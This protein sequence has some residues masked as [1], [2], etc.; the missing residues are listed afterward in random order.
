GAGPDRLH[1][2]RPP[3]RALATVKVAGPPAEGERSLGRPLPVNPAPRRR[4]LQ[5]SSACAA[6]AL[7]RGIRLR[8]NCPTADGRAL[9]SWWTAISLPNRYRRCLRRPPEQ[10]PTARERGR[11]RACWASAL[12]GSF[13]D[14]APR[15]PIALHRQRRAP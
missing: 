7:P 10:T 4:S 15:A 11:T 6:V 5:L 9:R 1:R 2:A 14:R 3:F 12:R 13:L 8:R